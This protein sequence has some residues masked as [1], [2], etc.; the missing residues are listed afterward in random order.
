M[1]NVVVL[2]DPESSSFPC[3]S[4]IDISIEI[5]NVDTTTQ[6]LCDRRCRIVLMYLGEMKNKNW[7]KVT[8]SSCRRLL[9]G[10]KPNAFILG[11]KWPRSL[12]NYQ[13]CFGVRIGV[14]LAVWIANYKRTWSLL[15][16]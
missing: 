10:K 15:P 4:G 2:D 14:T 16:T 7:C 1:L 3:R 12:V 13:R 6:C 5:R 11:S 9:M 8:Q